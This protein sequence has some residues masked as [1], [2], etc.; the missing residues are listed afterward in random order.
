M[1]D[2]ICFFD[3]DGTLFSHA[4]DSIPSST[5]RS[6]SLLQKNGIPIVLA[7]GRH[8]AELGQLEP[9]ASIPFDA[10]IMLTGAYI[11]DAGKSCIE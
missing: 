3:L 6:L 11:T 5:L 1:A 9:A 8:F 10:L 4:S 7:T 2:H